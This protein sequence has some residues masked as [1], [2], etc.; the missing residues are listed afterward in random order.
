M[1]L[2]WVVDPYVGSLSLNVCSCAGGKR[3]V[4]IVTSQDPRE[5]GCQL[6][7]Q[8]SWAVEEVHQFLSRRG[9]V[10]SQLHTPNPNHTPPSPSLPPSLPP[11]SVT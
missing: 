2:M 7:L 6:S 10:V 9:V 5:R 11:P 4:S 3:Y 1:R 8:F